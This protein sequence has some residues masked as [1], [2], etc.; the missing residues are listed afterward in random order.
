MTGKPIFILLCAVLFLIVL[1]AGTAFAHK[2]DI[3]AYVK[4][5]TVYTESYFPDGRPVKEGTVTVFAS[6]K[7]QLLEGKTDAQGLFSFAVPKVDD[8]TLV[9]DAG[10]GHK[11]QIKLK[12]STLR[13]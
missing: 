3:F 5:G 11:S 10:M 1:A 8:L 4:D 13:E 12:E 6:D 2:T 9:L 7:K